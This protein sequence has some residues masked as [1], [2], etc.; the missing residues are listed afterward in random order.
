MESVHSEVIA[1]LCADIHLQHTPPVARSAEPDWYAAMLRSLQEIYQLVKKHE[2]PLIIAGDIFER[3][4]S[5][6][7]LICFAVNVF[8]GIEDVYAVPGQHDLPNH[9]YEEVGRSAF[10][11]LDA[12]GVVR[13]IAD[14][15]IQVHNEMT[16]TG[17]PWGWDVLPYDPG[18]PGTESMAI[19]L[20]H[21]YCWMREKDAYPGAP[22]DKHISKWGKLLDGYDVAVFGD[23]HIGFSISVDTP[24]G[25]CLVVNC[26]TVMR[27]TRKEFLYRPAV[28]LLC[29]DKDGTIGVEPHYLD[30]SQDQWLDVREEAEL[31]ASSNMDLQQFM[32]ELE[33]LGDDS[34]DFTVALKQW[35][36]RED[37]GDS[38]RA[39]I[40]DAVEDGV[41]IS[42]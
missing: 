11:V 17:F 35:L 7:E 19:A 30:I 24:S 1:I 22:E 6:P 39:A 5:P 10:G 29:R 4:Q 37:V 21:S 13:D 3:W 41:G 36:E 33:D 20:I 15:G 25:T 14:F 26:G 40:Y 31:V 27:R 8:R 42:G 34:L 18:I 16:I 9:R 32:E 28:W 12:A 2:V 23:N 38:V